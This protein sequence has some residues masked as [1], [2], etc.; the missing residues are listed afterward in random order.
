MLYLSFLLRVKIMK[1]TLP[2]LRNKEGYMMIM[3][4][5]FLLLL[6]MTGIASLDTSNIEL[7]TALNNSL[8]KR[9]F[10]RAEAA[11]LEAIRRLNKLDEQHKE[12]GNEDDDDWQQKPYS[13]SVRDTMREPNNWNEGT[14]CK[15]SEII[16]SAGRFSAVGP[17]EVAGDSISG[18][19]SDKLI[20]YVVF[21]LYE[22]P[23]Y[24][25]VLIETAYRKRIPNE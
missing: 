8:Y 4:L 3:S 7:R 25:L 17:R 21:G 24:G 10:Y 18:T 15:A 16:G 1:K 12:F 20:E 5:V 22:D 14:N 9:N 6:T 11:N 19:A 13:D 23:S 2:I